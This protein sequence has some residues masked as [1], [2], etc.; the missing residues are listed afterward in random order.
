MRRHSGFTLIEIV[1][2]MAVLLIIIYLTASIIGSYNTP[3]LL[4][5]TKMF[6]NSQAR[7][8]MDRI[9]WELMQANSALVYENGTSIR[10]AVPIENATGELVRSSTGDL[11]WGDRQ[12]AGNYIRYTYSTANKTLYRQLL[13]NTT[14]LIA[15]TQKPISYNVTNFTVW[16]NYTCCAQYEFAVDFSAAKYMNKTLP[17]PVN[18]SIRFSVTPSN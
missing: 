15:G 8:A 14:T 12:T 4:V 5:E 7:Q 18:Y 10:F 13:D 6:V 3:S 1:V 9:S 17:E 2:A 11:L 16:R